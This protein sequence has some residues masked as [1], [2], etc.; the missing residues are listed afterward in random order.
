M[1]WRQHGRHGGGESPLGDLERATVM[2][3]ELMRHR[4]TAV[5][6]SVCGR[7]AERFHLRP[8]LEV[9]C[10]E[11]APENN[12]NRYTLDELFRDFFGALTMLLTSKVTLLGLHTLAQYVPEVAACRPVL[13]STRDRLARDCLE[14]FKLVSRLE[15]TATSCGCVLPE[16]PFF[17]TFLG[18]T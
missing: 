9:L 5:L 6:C 3:E 12:G 15:R 2:I 11:C 18:R 13:P 17:R 7:R 1:P 14:L 4:E 8:S 10:V 16:N